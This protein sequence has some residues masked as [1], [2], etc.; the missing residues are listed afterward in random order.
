MNQF[1]PNIHH[2]RS[3][4]LKDYDYSQEGLYFVTI[5]TK[6]KLC[7]FGYIKEDSVILNDIGNIAMKEWLNT[8]NI[9]HNIA[10]HDFVIMPNHIHFIIEIKPV[11]AY[12]IRPENNISPNNDY[13]DIKFQSPKQTI[14]SIVRGFKSNITRQLGYSIWQ[15]NYYEHII[16]NEESYYKIVNYI[17]NNPSNWNKDKFY[18]S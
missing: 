6:D 18:E 8:E 4:R 17:R 16:R 12:C 9:R 15:R 13:L 14:G 5:C 7:L 10:L 1:N 11:G 3:V 2:R